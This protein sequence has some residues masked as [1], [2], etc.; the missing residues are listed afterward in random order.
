MTVT[1]PINDAYIPGICNINHQE[2]KRRRNA[3]YFGLVLFV[4]VALPLVLVEIN[5]WARLIV[6]VPAFIAAIGLMQAQQ[7]FCVSYAASGLQ[8]ANEDST[9]ARAVQDSQKIIDKARARRM[10]FQAAA[11]AVFAT[12]LIVII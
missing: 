5:H 7:K 12:W 9:E 1:T 10:N 11:L 3:G 6:F 8:N 2:I 4:A